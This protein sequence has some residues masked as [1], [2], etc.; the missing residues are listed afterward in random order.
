MAGVV[1]KFYFGFSGI[2]LEHFHLEG[3]NIQVPRSLSRFL[4]GGVPIAIGIGV[5]LAKYKIR[6][7]NGTFSIK[8]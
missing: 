3:R 1:P 6:E 2:I 5:T 7:Q 8:R 4:A